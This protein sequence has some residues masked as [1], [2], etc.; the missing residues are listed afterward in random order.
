M[1]KMQ[2]CMFSRH[3]LFIWAGSNKF[4][5]FGPAARASFALILRFTNSH[6]RIRASRLHQ[7]LDLSTEEFTIVGV[8]LL[9][10]LADAAKKKGRLDGGPLDAL[11]AA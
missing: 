5:G 1:G 7:L 4:F 8:G 11:D 10:P 2:I 9:T 3:S 6:F